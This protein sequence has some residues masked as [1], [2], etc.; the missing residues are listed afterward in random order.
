MCSPYVHIDFSL[1]RVVKHGWH[2]LEV[3]LLKRAASG[4]FEFITRAARVKILPHEEF[5]VADKTAAL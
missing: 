3:M 4:P 1:A 5:F 2:G